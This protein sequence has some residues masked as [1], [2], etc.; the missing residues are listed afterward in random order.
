MYT[1]IF[2]DIN[3]NIKK[4]QQFFKLKRKE[5]DRE[6]KFCKAE[7]TVNPQLTGANI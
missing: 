3:F 5:M 2:K 7:D 4:Q 6:I 1:P